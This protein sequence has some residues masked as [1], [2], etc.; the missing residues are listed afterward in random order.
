[1]GLR[2]SRAGTGRRI[3]A[4]IFSV[5]QHC[6]LVEALARA[7]QPRLDHLAGWPCCCTTRPNTSSA[8]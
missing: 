2:A 6:L 1:M 3:G 8:T 7:Q 4:H 5:A